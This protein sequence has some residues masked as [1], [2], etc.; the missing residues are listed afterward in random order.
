M[1]VKVL[2]YNQYGLEAAHGTAVAADTKLLV[3]VTLPEDDRMVHI[4]EVDMG[5]R[6]NKLLSAAVVRRLVADGLGIEDQDGA[7]FQLFP[8]LLSCCLDGGVSPAEQTPA[9]GDYLWTFATDQTGAE[10]LDSMTLEA[11]DN[12]Q[13]Y[14]IPYVMLRSM[15]ITGD[16][17]SG[18][19]H[20][21]CDG[22]GQFVDQTTVTGGVA[23]PSV[24]MCVGK[25]SRIYIDD[26]WAGLGGTELT[27]SL[28]NWSV[29]INGG[30]HPKFW[31]SANR[32]YTSHQQ[33]AVTGEATF[34]FERNSS[35]ATEE[36][37]YRPAAGGVT[38]DDRFIELTVTGTQIGAGDNHTLKIDLA[39]Q[40]TAWA[41]LSAEEEGNSL[42]TAT[43]T[44]GYDTTGT[45]GLQ[46]LVTT[47]VSAI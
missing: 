24:E 30:G 16:C 43:F 5:V 13:A 40:W 34:T 23:I 15:T 18:E 31:G 14:E 1:G 7:Y 37:K 39:G 4:P 42:D 46:V 6:T 3:N 41:P 19:V 38:R 35:V 45:Q 22:F 44:V 32:Y 36:L 26:T 28:I 21:S 11:T 9:A 25:L 17:I 27:N 10:A 20:V 8:I 12:V 47:D 29:T 2:G 33:G